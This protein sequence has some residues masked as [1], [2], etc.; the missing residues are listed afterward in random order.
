ML[1][2]TGTESNMAFFHSQDFGICKTAKELLEMF[3]AQAN[4]NGIYMLYPQGRSGGGQKVYCDMTIDG[5]GWML[6]AR[7]HPSSGHASGWGWQGGLK[8]EVTNYSQAYQAGWYS[9]WH[10]YATF[11]SYIFGNRANIN[12]NNWGPFVY[13]VSNINYTTFLTSDTQQSYTNSTIQSNTSVYGTSAF[14][15]MQGAVGYAA[16]GTNNNIYY[17]RDCCGYAGYGAYP[18]YMNTV[19]CGADFYYSGPWC[20]GSTQDGSGNFQNGSYDANGKRFGGTN[21][22]MIMVK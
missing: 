11:T 16:T 13:K 12:N 1:S 5:G 8:G 18:T 17:M 21:Q 20:G 14:P 19:Y 22:Y 6:V 10:G 2:E 9:Y 4:Q 3:P 7:S 15:G